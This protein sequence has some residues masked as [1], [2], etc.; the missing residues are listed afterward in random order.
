MGTSAWFAPAAAAIQMVEAIF[1]D[2][3]RV[4]PC[5]VEL[6]KEYGGGY[7]G[8]FLGVPC[9][10][11]KNGLEKVLELPLTPTEKELL[12]KSAKAVK[13]VVDVANKM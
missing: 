1:H 13:E 3:K 12:D 11:G 10:L 7:K 4:L 2:S 9:V 5:S 6:E 8:L